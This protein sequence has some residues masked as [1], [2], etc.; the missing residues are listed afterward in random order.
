MSDKRHPWFL[1]TSIGLSLLVASLV[2]ITRLSIGP[3]SPATPPSEM[4]FIPAGEF[5][6][7]SPNGHPDELP[8]H[9]VHLEPFHID[10]Y[11]VTNEQYL[12]FIQSVTGL[13]EDHVCLDRKADNPDS[14]IVYQ[15][16]RYTV[17][18]GYEQHPVTLVSWYGAQAYCQYQGKRLPAEAEWE[19]AARG[20]DGRTYPWGDVV[21]RAR[22]NAGCR[23][24]DTTAV[25]SYPGGASPYGVYDLAGN[26]WEWTADWYRAYPDSSYHSPFFGDRY[27][28][29]RGGSWNHPDSDARTTQRDLAHP[30]R[31]IRVVG[32][33]C[34]RSP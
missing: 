32:F 8:V 21:D 11:E 1:P 3:P 22:L 24:G 27:K 6:M 2:T 16:G 18:A 13:C 30:A 10:R 25:G 14:H 12:Q 5:T 34:A 9:P 31:R 20:P 4:A 7:G 23:V 19:K 26:V 28:V 29:L 17:E 33:R 15:N